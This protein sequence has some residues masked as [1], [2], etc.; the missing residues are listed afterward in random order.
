MDLK[1]AIEKHVAWKM[2][3]RAAIDARQTMDQVA[4]AK[5]NVCDLGAWLHGPGRIE[6]SRCASFD[7]LIEAHR[8]FHV[9]AGRIAA[10]INA[11]NFPEA[12]R[13]LVGAA[14]SAASQRA[15]MAMMSIQREKQSQAA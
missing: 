7:A 8:E 9:E 4:I 12:E 15:V 5:D 10:A 1:Q 13:L 14:Y 11:K 3:F 6:C 2:K